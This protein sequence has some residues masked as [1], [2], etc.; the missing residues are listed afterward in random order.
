MNF[1][2]AY[3]RI[4]K[5]NDASA[6]VKVSTLQRCQ[7]SRNIAHVA[8]PRLQ[9]GRIPE[10]RWASCSAEVLF[11]I[12]LTKIIL[13]RDRLK[14]DLPAVVVN[15][16]ETMKSRYIWRVASIRMRIGRHGASDGRRR[17]HSALFC[18]TK[19]EPFTKEKSAPWSFFFKVLFSSFPIN[20]HFHS[21]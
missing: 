17:G 12:P 21:W 4:V 6:A 1:P 8:R 10:L 9:R 2:K 7:C 16:H 3:L 19:R 20:S 11:E 5:N 18:P 13:R 15:I 14:V